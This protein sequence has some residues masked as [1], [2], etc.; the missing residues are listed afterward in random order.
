MTA[1][2]PKNLKP[3]QHVRMT[4]V[5]EG[6]VDIVGDQYVTID[7]GTAERYHSL[8]VTA[9]DGAVDTWELVGGDPS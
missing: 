2:D 3:G 6:V 5:V 9:S 1:I 7:T 4:H 8:P